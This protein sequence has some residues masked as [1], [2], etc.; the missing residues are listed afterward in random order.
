VIFAAHELRSAKARESFFR[1]LFRVLKPGGT[2]LLVE[3]LRDW[4]NF[5]A[6]GP[7]FL[8]FFSHREWTRLMAAA[9]F[10]LTSESGITPWVRVF[11]L[12]K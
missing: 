12:R 6:Y 7:G 5:L 3:H 11:Q 4:K 9:S 8:H 10:Q 2:V 1:E